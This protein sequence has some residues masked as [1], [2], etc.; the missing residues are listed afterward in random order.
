MTI[1]EAAAAAAAAAGIPKPKKK[2]KL[3]TRAAAESIDVASLL[4][5]SVLRGDQAPASSP[6]AG[7]GAE[8]D[9]PPRQERLARAQTLAAEQAAAT[10]ALRLGHRDD[11]GRVM[12]AK[13]ASAINATVSTTSSRGHQRRYERQIKQERALAGGEL[14]TQ[15]CLA[16]H[17]ARMGEAALSLG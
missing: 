11:Q 8:T 14:A 3:R 5:D 6:V 4:P 10:E 1:D 17:Q 2:K 13:E 12:S 7:A 16:L 15:K 9:G